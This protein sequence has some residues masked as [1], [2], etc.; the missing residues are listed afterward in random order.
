MSSDQTKS[1]SY[2]PIKATAAYRR[3]MQGYYLM[4]TH[5]KWIGKKLAWITSGGPVEPLYAMGVLPFYPE[6]YGAMCGAG[7]EAVSLCETAESQGYS[8][9][10]CSYARLDIGSSLSGKGPLGVL[11][12]PDFLVCANNICGTVIKWYEIQA[13]KFRVPLFFLDIPFIHKDLNDHTLQYVRRQMEE[14]VA[15]L[16]KVCRRP[17]PEK[18]FLKV[19]AR[20]IEAVGLWKEILELSRIHPAPFAAFDAFIHMAPIVTLRGTGWAVRY[21]QKLKK[22]LEDR[23]EKGQGAFAREEIRLIWDNIPIWYDIRNLSRLLARQGAVLVADTYTSAWTLKPLDMDNPLESLSRS[24]ASVLLNLGLEH[25]VSN[26]AEL[27]KQYQA[28]G[29]IMHSNR[30]CKTYSLGQ[31]DIRKR[32]SELTGKP[33]LIIEA[34]HTDSRSY[35]PVQVEKQIEAFV[36]MAREK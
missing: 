30:S 29:F 25:K 23:V 22:E 26:M 5:P 33:G 16:E 19:T 1:P 31:Y 11:P 8:R 21:Y 35:A 10:L 18:R 4:A 7:R 34:D 32:V 24:Y 6:N 12:K 9:D 3:L 27:M 28:D 17:F 14:Y 13:R 15:F 20:S 36:E 2:H